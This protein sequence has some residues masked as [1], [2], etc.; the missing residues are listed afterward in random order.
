M[1]ASETPN[2]KRRVMIPVIAGMGN[3]LMAMPMVRQIKRAWPDASITILARD[4]GMAE[5]YRRM[6]E[7]VDEVLC[8]GVGLK[9]LF[10]SVRWAWQRR[11]DVYLIPFPSNR[12]HYSLLALTS[13]AN[14]KALHSYPA[15]YWRS[16]GFIG[17]R[18]PAERKIHDV[19]QNLRLLKLLEIEPDESE[20]PRFVVTES[21]RRRAREMIEST[22]MNPDGGFIAV[23]AGSGSYTV[24]ASAKRW[25]AKNYG[26]L[27]DH[28][29]SEF[30]LP[31]L[32]LEGPHEAGVADAIVRHANR[33]TGFQPVPEA[34]EP[35]D[36]SHGLKARV[37]D[38]AVHVLKVHGQLGEAA[39]VL[40]RAT[41]YVGSDSGLAHLAASVG[42]RAVTIFAPADPDRVSPYG[43]RDLVVQTDKPCSPCFTYPFQTPYTDSK[44][45]EPYCIEA[46]TVDRVMDAVRRAL[47]VLPVLQ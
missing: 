11:P 36:R 44:C 24:I 26:E 14:V 28:M 29:R 13:R 30:G 9:A 37:T 20:K 32:L 42:K 25:P 21:D 16:L 31:V 47:A 41:V 39:A 40:E 27:I 3:A 8:T 7:I 17:M 10:R 22:G 5:P 18:M 15:G 19:I 6:P 38:S 1:T 35:Q 4:D 2:R 34:L 43:S 45:R 33:D 23:H 46:V 12:W